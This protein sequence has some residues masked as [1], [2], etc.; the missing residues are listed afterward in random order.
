MSIKHKLGIIAAVAAVMTQAC[1][2]TS[3][4]ATSTDEGA[5]T[6]T[7]ALPGCDVPGMV[8]NP[9][10]H[11]A[12]GVSVEGAGELTAKVTVE[13]KNTLDSMAVQ[14]ALCY[15]TDTCAIYNFDGRI[16][17]SNQGSGKKIWD[18]APAGGGEYY[19][20]PTGTLQLQ[21][22]P[23][24][25][26]RAAV[27]FYYYH[28]TDH[29][30]EQKKGLGRVIA[31][32]PDGAT[33]QHQ[34]YARLYL[35]PEN[36]DSENIEAWSAAETE[37]WFRSNCG[38]PAKGPRSF[39][40][41]QTVKNMY[42]PTDLNREVRVDCSLS[43][44]DQGEWNGSSYNPRKFY[45]MNSNTGDAQLETVLPGLEPGQPYFMNERQGG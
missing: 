42:N 12:W 44:P 21:A 26:V 38:Q 15:L 10:M 11:Q 28:Y 41:L 18:L 20:G 34:R 5:V 45:L 33:R 31:A 1:G 39:S 3:E 23:A 8:E 6:P 14:T 27:I 29:G 37:T 17:Y 30:F 32:P 19:G 16:T 40:V 2:G 13:D 25:Q 4:E 35:C 43:A 7:G 9:L 36:L 22:K 24:N